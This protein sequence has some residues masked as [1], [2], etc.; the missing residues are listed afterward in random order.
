MDKFIEALTQLIPFAQLLESWGLAKETSVAVA[1]A[2]IALLG[3]AAKA[4]LQY[5]FNRYKNSKA[6]HDLAPHFDYQT[7]QIYATMIDKW[8]EREAN[9][10]KYQT[11]ARGKFKQDLRE[12]S[13]LVALEIYRQGQQAA[14]L[15][16]P[17][18]AALAIARKH[19]I[20]LQDYEITGQS[21]LTRDAEGNWKFAHKSI[22]A[23]F[24]AEETRE[25]LGFLKEIDFA[26][27]DKVSEYLFVKGGTFLMGSPE[28][29]VGR[30]ENETQHQVKVDDFFISKYPVTVAQFE[31]FIMESGYRTDADN[32][33]SSNI[34]TGKKWQSKTGVN[35][36]CDVKGDEQKD[37]QHPVIHVS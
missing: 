23:F 4:L 5:L 21:L 22:L 27:M 24:I 12:Y 17:K 20:D 10:R 2:I 9:K 16:L 26:G 37:K 36:R 18:E 15:H 34:W 19:H 25:N 7:H 30:R 31:R 6:A 8:L 11:R 28:S 13:R 3:A 35:W 33:G 29:E 14:K 32:Y 1:G